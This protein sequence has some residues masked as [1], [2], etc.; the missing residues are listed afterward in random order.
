MKISEFIACSKGKLYFTQHI[1]S[2]YICVC[3]GCKIYLLLWVV[4]SKVWKTLLQISLVEKCNL[5]L[6]E[7]IGFFLELE[8]SWLALFSLHC[9]GFWAE[10]FGFVLCPIPEEW[11][12]LSFSKSSQ[13]IKQNE[14]LT[15][16]SCLPKQ[17]IFTSDFPRDHHKGQKLDSVFLSALEGQSYW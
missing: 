5:I 1:S 7:W 16:V 3:K 11:K 15:I 2:K 13:E 8:R 9:G 10:Y 4:K 17:M 12:S 6:P 14:I